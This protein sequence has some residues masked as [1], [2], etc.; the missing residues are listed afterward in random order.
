MLKVRNIFWNILFFLVLSCWCLIYCSGQILQK[1]SPDS[2]KN[3]LIFLGYWIGILSPVDS[4]DII[5]FYSCVSGYLIILA[6]LVIEKKLIDYIDEVENTFDILDPID[7]EIV[8]EN[9][10]LK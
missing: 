9:K 1:F 2:H 8:Q 6:L 10:I 5:S 4:L 7:D 3:Q